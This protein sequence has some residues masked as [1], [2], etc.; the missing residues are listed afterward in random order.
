MCVCLVGIDQRRSTAV[1]GLVG[2]CGLGLASMCRFSWV[3]WVGGI[4]SRCSVRCRVVV[5]VLP[6]RETN[7]ESIN[8]LINQSINQASKQ[9]IS[10]QASN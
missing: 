2:R 5:C 3:G 1:V 10:K 6:H 7:E 8:Q 4:D 9:V